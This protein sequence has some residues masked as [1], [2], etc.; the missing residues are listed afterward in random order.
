MLPAPIQP[1]AAHRS[2]ILLVEDEP[3]VRQMAAR[4]LHRGGYTVLEADNPET[5]R[6]LHREH[7]ASI[8]LL[9]TDVV[10]PQTNGRQLARELCD[11]TPALKVLY[12]SGY[13]DGVLDGPGAA[14][15]FTPFLEKPFTPRTLLEKVHGVLLSAASN[16]A[17]P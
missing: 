13:L 17:T 14:E 12:M 10:M 8:D 7:A 3:A 6:V 15:R 4:A 16:R 11:S 2:T 5:A 1:Q 9:I